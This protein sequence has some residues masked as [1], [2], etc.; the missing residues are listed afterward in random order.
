MDNKKIPSTDTEQA[1]EVRDAYHHGS[2]RES[3]IA[4]ADDILSERGV[5]G[6]TL[7]E[8]ARRAGVSVAAPAHHFGSAAGLLSEVANLGF[9]EL[10]RYLKEAGGALTGAARMRALG[11]AY[12]CF[13]L[14]YPGRFHL[15]FR[16]DLLLAEEARLEIAGQAAL[17][18]VEQA[19]RLYLGMAADQPLDKVARTIKL[20]AWSTVHGFAH[21]ALDGKFDNLAMMDAG[22]GDFLEDIL[23][24]V[25][26]AQWPDNK[27]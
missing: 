1:R 16:H 6:F 14:A 17:A 7:R 15:M 3:L 25:L 9:A 12:V 20:L 23:P 19:V 11:K 26:L 10:A 22:M 4:A 5:A 18:E 2:L 13:A 21:L 24:A 27:A 8:A